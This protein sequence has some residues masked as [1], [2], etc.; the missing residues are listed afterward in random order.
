MDFLTQIVVWLNAVANAL[1]SALAFVGFMPGWLS[2]TLIAIVSG[3]A[4]ILGFKWTSNQKAVKRTRQD[5]RA[6]MLAVKLYYDNMR[7]GFRSLGRVLVLA[8]RML[9]F[10]VV[11]ILAMLIPVSLLLGQMALWYQ[12]RPLH[13]GDTTIVVMKLA[14]EGDAPMPTATLE[15]NSAIEVAHGPVQIV[16]QREICWEVRAK[17]NGVQRLV[18]HVDG[19]PVE[20]ELSIGDGFM[21]VSLR[22]PDWDW[23]EAMLHPREAPFSTTSAVRSIDVSYPNRSSQLVGVPIWMLHWFVVSLLAGFLC[24]GLFKVSL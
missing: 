17:E 1:G 22:R 4:M 10:A 20:K 19:Q 16:S 21:P 15:T 24:R 3:M 6:N 8:M 11:P 23:S 9:V 14:G 13:V 5:I 2:L 7:V 18:F 12:A